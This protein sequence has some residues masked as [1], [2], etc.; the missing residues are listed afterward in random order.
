MTKKI[1]VLF[2]GSGA[3]GGF[4]AG[5][6]CHLHNSGEINL[7]YADYY[8]TSSGAINAVAFSK[9]SPEQVLKMWVT[10]IYNISS[11]FKLNK[12]PFRWNGIFNAEPLSK[13]LLDVLPPVSHAASTF[14]LFDLS[15]G[16]LKYIRGHQESLPSLINY[17]KS[18]V[19]IP[20]IVESVGPL[21][22]GGAKELCPLRQAIDDGHTE[23][24][25]F[26]GDIPQATPRYI[27]Y[28]LKAPMTMGFAFV[29]SLLNSILCH[30]IR[31]AIAKNYDPK[32]QKINLKIYAPK[33]PLSHALDFSNS[34]AMAG[35]GY[36]GEYIC[37]DPYNV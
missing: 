35:L 17:I 37:I 16:S 20:G 7:D 22:D 34:S 2:S 27:P 13:F 33:K 8:G 36:S 11:V 3:K 23:L 28:G 5:M 29:D 21:V 10:R 9:L 15:V 32:K 26:M 30:D 31:A 6:A 19:A 12:N 4:Q 14:N 1:A 18:A 25:L 24:V